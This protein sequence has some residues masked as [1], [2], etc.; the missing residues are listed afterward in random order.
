MLLQ[1][2]VPV[3]LFR[4]RFADHVQSSSDSYAKRLSNGRKE[5]FVR[6]TAQD[7]RALAELLGAGDVELG[8]LRWVT[9]MKGLPT[10]QPSGT[11]WPIHRRTEEG[12]PTATLRRGI[13]RRG[14]SGAAVA[15]V[16]RSHVW[17][18]GEAMSLNAL[19]SQVPPERKAAASAMPLGWSCLLDNIHA[20]LT[21]STIGR[22]ASKAKKARRRN[23]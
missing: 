16:G 7:H 6:C 22:E 19:P 5:D 13:H 15:A 18:G 2:I 9:S 10:I 8:F 4:A 11:R 20:I 3:P 21:V 12:V 17:K 23:I 1:R 14:H